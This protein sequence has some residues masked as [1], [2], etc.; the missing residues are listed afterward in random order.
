M[1]TSRT[2][3]KCV[4]AW[5]RCVVVWVCRETGGPGKSGLEMLTEAMGRFH[6]KLLPEQ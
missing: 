3:V 5:P 1:Y 2:G 4:G 6:S